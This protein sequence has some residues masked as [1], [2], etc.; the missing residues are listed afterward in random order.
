[1][2]VVTRV[3]TL[4]VVDEADDSFGTDKLVD[5]LGLQTFERTRCRFTVC[6]CAWLS[7]LRTFL[8]LHL[9]RA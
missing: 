5:V 6:Q 8:Y 4:L 3:I 1:M 9:C 2:T 7:V